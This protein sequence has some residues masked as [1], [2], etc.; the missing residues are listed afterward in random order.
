MPE[1]AA[2]LRDLVAIDRFE[3]GNPDVVP[4]LPRIDRP[5]ETEAD[6]REIGSTLNL[7]KLA[8]AAST[9]TRVQMLHPDWEQAEVDAEVSRI[10]AESGTVVD[11][12]T[13]GFPA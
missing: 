13:G 12:P 7:I 11:D 3:F 6:L 5:D 10:L 1:L 8:E 4:M 9:Q 2:A